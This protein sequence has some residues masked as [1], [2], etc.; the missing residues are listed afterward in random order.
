MRG[1]GG[2]GGWGGMIRREK[3]KERRYF[4]PAGAY[5]V[6]FFLFCH[7]DLEGPVISILST[8]TTIMTRKG[9]L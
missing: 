7:L 4:L 1:G 6:F 5:A 9:S 3:G 2:G 8:M